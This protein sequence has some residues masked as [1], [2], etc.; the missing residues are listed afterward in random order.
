MKVILFMAMSV[1]GI[2]ARK[3]GKE[4]FLSDVGW[5][6][7]QTLSEKSGCFIIGRKTYEA[8]QKYYTKYG[9]LDVKSKRIIVSKSMKPPEGF[10]VAESPEAALEKAKSWKLKSVLLSGGSANNMSFMKSGLVDEIILNV[11]P[12][13][14]GAGVPV[15]AEG[16][17]ESK[18]K[19]INIKRGK[20][21]IQ[22]HYKV[23]K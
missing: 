8:C 18:L 6:D 16:E 17:L 3:S 21:V 10:E 4:D 15:F 2:I 7:F 5:Y 1:N 22:L 19:L 12:V 11:E 23:V 14:V 13:V 20:G 9:M